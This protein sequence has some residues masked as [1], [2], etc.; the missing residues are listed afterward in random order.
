[1]MWGI[2]IVSK[3][4]PEDNYY[5]REDTNFIIE[6]PGQHHINQVIKVRITNDK[7]TSSAF[8]C[9]ALRIHHFHGVLTKNVLSMRNIRQTKIE[10]YPMK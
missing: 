7:L 5:V 2:Y 3:Y 4:L 8:W 10:S 9:N 1:M 6:K